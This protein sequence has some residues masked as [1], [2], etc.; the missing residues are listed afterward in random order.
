M[1]SKRDGPTIYCRS[2]ASYLSSE[3]AVTARVTAGFAALFLSSEISGTA[4]V[5]TATVARVYC[6]SV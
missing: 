6:C 3:T 1:L 4:D 2:A 5:I